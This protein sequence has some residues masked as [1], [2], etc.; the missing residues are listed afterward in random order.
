MSMC[1]RPQ[2]ILYEELYEHLSIFILSHVVPTRNETWRKFNIPLRYKTQ[3][4]YKTKLLQIS[5]GYLVL[6]NSIL[7]LILNK[8]L[9]PNEVIQEPLMLRDVGWIY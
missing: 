6:V 4:Y 2:L 7:D 5:F 9:C 3:N 8:S 1:S